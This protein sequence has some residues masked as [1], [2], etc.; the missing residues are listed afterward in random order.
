MGRSPDVTTSRSK[1]QKKK[2]H[3]DVTRNKYSRRSRSR[4]VDSDVTESRSRSR[5]SRHGSMKSSRRS[6][7]R[8]PRRRRSRSQERTKEKRKKPRKHVNAVMGLATGT[9]KDVLDIVPGFSQMNPVERSKIRVKRALDAAVE[10]SNMEVEETDDII[11]DII[12]TQEQVKRAKTIEAIDDADEFMPTH[13][14]SS[15]SKKSN[16]TFTERE[17][18]HESAI[19][20]HMTMLT[21]DQALK[22]KKENDDAAIF[23][24]KQKVNF[25]ER[26]PKTL[27]GP[28][29]MLNTEEANTRWRHKLS[30]IR[31]NLLKQ[32]HELP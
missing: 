30:T 21:F 22:V 29:L 14:K 2:S 9:M 1:K 27:M 31:E 19:F 4:S 17:S 12:N 32:R 3:D 11:D 7:S 26:D 6:R 23:K 20:G 24:A 25:Y 28:K 15:K 8:S 5:D 13:F 16:N 10:T 18:N